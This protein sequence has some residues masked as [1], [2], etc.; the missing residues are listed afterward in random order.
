MAS[1]SLLKTHQG[2]RIV[3]P[4][5]KQAHET[6]NSQRCAALSSTFKNK[7]LAAM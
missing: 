6:F 7:E 5:R 1:H 3:P 2:P 4:I